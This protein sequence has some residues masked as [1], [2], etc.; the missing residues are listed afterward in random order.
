MKSSAALR[1]RSRPL[2]AINFEILSELTK[3][4]LKCS[5]MMRLGGRLHFYKVD[6]AVDEIRLVITVEVDDLK[7]RWNGSH[8]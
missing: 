1:P 7:S 5:G 4:T 6:Y 8:F 2:S 3:M